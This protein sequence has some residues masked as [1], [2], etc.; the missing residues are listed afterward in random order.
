MSNVNQI[1]APFRSFNGVDL[2]RMANTL[3]P[4]EFRK[5]IEM[6]REQRATAK[7]PAK[8]AS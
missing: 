4:E 1:E 8:K 6:L 7:A 2:K 3:S 5:Y